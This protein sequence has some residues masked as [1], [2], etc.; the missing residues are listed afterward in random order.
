MQ[1]SRTS[2]FSSWHPSLV[3]PEGSTEC[4]RQRRGGG[5]RGAADPGGV[6]ELPGAGETKRDGEA[7]LG[8]ARGAPLRNAVPS[9]VGVRGSPCPRTGRGGVADRRG[10]KQLLCAGYCGGCSRAACSLVFRE[11]LCR[12]HVLIP[13]LQT[14]LWLRTSESWNSQDP[15]HLCECLCL[16]PLGSCSPFWQHG[17]SPFLPPCLSG[18]GQDA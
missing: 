7:G 3:L 5:G 2:D 8:L 10:G 4:A 12:R 15:S 11:T 1:I 16:D 9:S 18:R 14:K 6:S 13:N 17:D